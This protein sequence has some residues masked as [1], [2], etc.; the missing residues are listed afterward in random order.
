MSKVL[1]GIGKAGNLV[2][3]VA[4]FSTLI[5]PSKKQFFNRVVAA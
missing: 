5:G 1:S 2:I 3:L 4:E